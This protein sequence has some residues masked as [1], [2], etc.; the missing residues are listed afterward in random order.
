M[1]NKII[2]TLKIILALILLWAI[3]FILMIRF[4]DGAVTNGDEIIFGYDET[5]KRFQ[6]FE[7][8]I[9]ELS[10]IDGPYVINNK[11]IR[12]DKNKKITEES[13]L[14]DTLLIR[15]D[16]ETHDSFYVTLKKEYKN[17]NW[18]YEQPEKLI[19]ISDIE[20]N[21]NGFS[22][23][24]QKNGVI[25]EQFNWRFGNGHLVLLGDFVDRGY[26]VTPTLWLIYKLEAEAEKKGGKVHFIL[27][28]HEIMNIHGDFRYA[29]SKYKKLAQV[30]GKS[31]DPKTNYRT[32]FAKNTELGKWMRSK[33]IAE[34]I[35]KYIF[36]HAGIS[37]R[38]LGYDIPF[39]EINNL[40]RENI[41]KDLYSKPGGNENANFVMGRESPYWYRGLAT[42]YKYYDKITEPELD[43]IL[44]HYD[45]QKIIIGHTIVEDITTDFNGKLIKIDLKHGKEKKSGKTKGLLIENSIEFSIND[46][47]KKKKL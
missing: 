14:S 25:D 7:K 11:I 32:L 20:G 34:K 8:K 43:K 33:N 16:N 39:S 4:T 2:K 12:V 1:K 29:R 46:L 26:N 35:G 10:G 40:L 22:S 37:P 45:G 17:P 3:G 47:S 13:I 18:G 15:V 28:N 38:I 9:F 44:K 41:D 30:I 31:D 27:G 21:F 24:L 36:V 5:N 42:D 23:F 19:A 6:F